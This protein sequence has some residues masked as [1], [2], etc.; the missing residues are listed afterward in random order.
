MNPNLS[1]EFT[2]YLIQCE[3]NSY[4]AGYA[5]C[6]FDVILRCAF[7][8]GEKFFSSSSA[9]FSAVVFEFFLRIMSIVVILY[10]HYR[11]SCN[12]PV[13]QHACKAIWT[14]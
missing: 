13:S 1:D 10:I 8:S 5:K 6:T 12:H 9:T 3:S 4:K 7:E 11:A 14:E 2:C